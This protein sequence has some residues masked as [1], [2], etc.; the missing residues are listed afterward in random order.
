MSKLKAFVRYDGN[1]RIIPGGP[2]LN[3][4]KPKVGNWTEINSNICCQS[5]TGCGAP[6]YINRLETGTNP[7]LWMP[8]SSVTDSNCNT[9]AAYRVGPVTEISPGEYISKVAVI[10]YD[11]AGNTLWQKVIQFGPITN[12]LA[13]S[14]FIASIEVDSNNDI[15][16]CTNIFLCKLTGSDGSIVWMQYLNYLNPPASLANIQYNVSLHVTSKDELF[17][18]FHYIT[19]DIYVTPCSGSFSKTKTTITK[20]NPSTGTGIAEKTVEFGN[21]IEGTSVQLA[22]PTF[23]PINSDT[24]GNIY[25]STLC[26]TCDTS[27]PL[28]NKVTRLNSTIK[29]DSNLNYLSNFQFTV[30]P[31]LNV[32]AYDVNGFAALEFYNLD[33]DKNNNI[34]FGAYGNTS[35]FSGSLFTHRIKLDSNY[36]LQWCR[37][38]N[39][40]GTLD[41]LDC[42]FT[43]VDSDGNSYILAVHYTDKAYL[44]KFDTNG[45]YLWATSIEDSDLVNLYGE[46]WF[47]NANQMVVT[48]DV[49]SMT[50]GTPDS[51]T[52]D[53]R[54]LFIKYPKDSQ[55][56]GTYGTTTFT[57]ATSEFTITT[58]N[59][60]IISISPI[61][62]ITNL[63]NTN[64]QPITYSIVP[65]TN[66]TVSTTPI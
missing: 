30:N 33:I 29:F 57:D 25:I 34:Y 41:S 17:F 62:S 50:L 54:A 19:D 21:T 48:N 3:R 10:K 13:S 56:L 22:A 26:E 47:W 15:Y 6:F 49:L 55:L 8:G 11:K 64:L 58:L 45:N 43:T 9:I 24:D 2:I 61:V 36:N 4:F 5:A 53:A 37:K 1:G 52:P 27:N 18:A 32:F 14:A 38:I 59:P 31:A 40:T 66:Y 46:L 51:L 60:V 16:L 12:V 23:T 7:D 65:A 28:Q 20:L 42:S 63:Y 39:Y 35:T 44:L